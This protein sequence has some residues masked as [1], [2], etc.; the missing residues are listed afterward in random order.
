MVAS[1]WRWQRPPPNLIRFRGHLTVGRPLK[2]L[3]SPCC[4]YSIPFPTGPDFARVYWAQKKPLQ[5]LSHRPHQRSHSHQLLCCDSDQTHLAWSG[6]GPISPSD[7]EASLT[8]CSLCFL[9]SFSIHP[10]F[11]LHFCLHFLI[12]I[13]DKLF[14][15]NWVR[16][17]GHTGE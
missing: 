17:C 13:E 3:P 4:S 16:H 2:P 7:Q 10:P 15:Q 5:V 8:H 12:V 1:S 9:P 14:G 6:I 11:S